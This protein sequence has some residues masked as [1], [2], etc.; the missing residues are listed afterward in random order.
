MPQD[1]SSSLNYDSTESLSSKLSL[2]LGAVHDFTEQV[3]ARPSAGD[4]SAPLEDLKRMTQIGLLTAPL[5]IRVG[6]LGLGT[7]ANGHLP[8]M[9]ILAML[10]GADL[11]LGRLYEGHVN[12]L[13]LIVSYGT[14]QQ[15]TST[16]HDAAEGRLFGVW[17][18]G[19][20]ES[21]RIEAG[22]GNFRMAGGKT[23]ASGAPFVARPIVTGELEGKGWQMTMPAMDSPEISSVVKLDSGFWHPMGMEASQSYSVDFSGVLLSPKDLIGK[24]GDFYRDPLFRGGA[25]RF[26]A[27]HAGATLRLNRMF[28]EWLIDRNRAEDPYQL[29]R[30]GEVTMSAQQAV[31]WVESA[32]FRAEKGLSVDVSNLTSDEMVAFA[33]MTRLSIEKIAT[34]VMQRVQVGIGAHGLLQ[35]S[36]FEKMIRDLSMYLRQPAPDQTLA[37]VGRASI[38]KTRLQLDGAESDMWRSDSKDSSLPPAYF[39][40]IYNQSPDPWNFEGSEYEA[41]KYRTTLANLPREVY[42]RALEVGCSIG[43]L[44]YQLATRCASILAID[45]SEKA[46]AAARKRCAGLGNVR[47]EKVHIPRQMPKGLFDLILISEVAYYWNADDLNRA[48]TG[49]SELQE[50]GDHLMLVHFTGPVP[51]YP[52]TAEQVHD[53][54]LGRPEWKPI[55]QERHEGYRLDLLERQ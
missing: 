21:L 34:S 20:G 50:R 31:M 8:L 35:P 39:Q 28:A 12:A 9:R 17:N 5:P 33:N 32:A 47:F 45:V 46:L 1:D 16:A 27:V 37:E 2:L 24:P 15:L 43:V 44:T 10:G 22:G 36:R 48:A 7:E 29:A 55:R 25:I 11:V 4:V 51:E 19:A 52:Q 23:F 42:A 30:L 41:G 26:A 13:I 38:R 3:A 54:W 14:D 40:A 53:Y 18:T 49:M 6:G